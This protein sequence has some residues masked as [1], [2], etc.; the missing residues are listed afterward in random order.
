METLLEQQSVVARP[1][2]VKEL[3]VELRELEFFERLQLVAESEQVVAPLDVEQALVECEEVEAQ[4]RVLVVVAWNSSY[5][6]CSWIV[7][8]TVCCA[9]C[10]FSSEV[11]C[12]RPH[13]SCLRPRPN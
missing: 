8:A 6:I 12:L 11:V 13:C 7:Y 4:Q 3:L 2:L 5:R 1:R 10:V 9:C